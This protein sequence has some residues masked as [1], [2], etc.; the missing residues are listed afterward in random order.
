MPRAVGPSDF[1]LYAM[2]SEPSF[3]PDGKRVAFS[4]RRANLEDDSY[5][6]DVYI[7]DRKGGR[8]SPITTG[9]KDSDPRWS[10]DG[11]SIL[12]TSRR[13]L[14]KDDK[15][16]ALYVISAD[17]GEARLLRRSEDGIESPRWSPDSK[18]AYF[19]SAV[20]RKAKDDVKVIGRINFW[21]NGLGFIYDKRKHLFRVDLDSGKVVQVTSGSVDLSDFAVSH[22]GKAIAYLASSNDLKP[23]VSD[24]YLTDPQ[25]K[26]RRRLTKSNME[27]TSLAWSPDGRMVALAGDDFPSG[28]ASHSRVW[29]VDIRTGKAERIDDVDL[30]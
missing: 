8:F 20:G 26:K 27:L 28:L 30:N 13:G 15:G 7:A 11:S 2:L 17:G 5:D 6:S 1:R 14:K 19:L 24:L 25:G 12:F 29:T 4:V 22:D 18:S 9:K 10:P 21:F 23:Y 3:S 16:N